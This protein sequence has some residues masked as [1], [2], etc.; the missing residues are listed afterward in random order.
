MIPCCKHCGIQ[1]MYCREHLT[2]GNFLVFDRATGFK[3]DCGKIWK[4][5]DSAMGRA[6]RVPGKQKTG[7]T[8][9]LQLLR[10][11]KAGPVLQSDL[12]MFR[13]PVS[14]LQNCRRHGLAGSGL[15]IIGRWC[16]SLSSKYPHARQRVY[17]LEVVSTCA[18]TQ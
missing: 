18:A 15:G 13:D 2:Y 14:A 10:M 17:T 5:I 6:P 12:T 7:W 1:I 9:T 3:H 4:G 8:D 11:L 16:C